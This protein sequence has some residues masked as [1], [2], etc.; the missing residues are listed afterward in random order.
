M[1][2]PQHQAKPA[3]SLFCRETGTRGS[4]AVTRTAKAT[5]GTLELGAGAEE[6]SGAWGVE[7][8]DGCRGNWRDPPRSRPAGSGACPPIT[9]NGKWRAAER[10]SEGVVLPLMAGTT[11]P[12][13]REGPL[14]HRCTRKEGGTL[15]SAEQSARSVRQADGLDSVRALQRVLYRV[16]S[17]GSSP[18]DG[19]AGDGA[20][21]P[22]R[23]ARTAG[24]STTSASTASGEKKACECRTASASGRCGVS[25]CDKERFV[26]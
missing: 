2:S 14:L 7:W 20:V 26:T 22:S 10:E 17:Y 1:A 21:P 6:P 15:M 8:S 13:R 3:A 9:G 19:R 16:A 25:V 11:Q 4:R 18:R 12:G 24:P 23:P 5:E